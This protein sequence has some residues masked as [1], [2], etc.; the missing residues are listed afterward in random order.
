MGDEIPHIPG[1]PGAIFETRLLV[2]NRAKTIT[3]QGTQ[4]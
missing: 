2:Q 1:L 3:E 4:A